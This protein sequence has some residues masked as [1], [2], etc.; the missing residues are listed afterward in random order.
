MA[1]DFFADNKP[2]DQT[3]TTENALSQSVRIGEKEYSYEDASR[4]VGLGEQA[5][6]L[7]TRWDTKIDK[8]MPAYSKSREEL[9]TLKEQA[10]ERAN[11][12]IQSKEA[13]GED[14]SEAEKAKLV[15]DEAKKLGL[16]TVDDL[17]SYYQNRRGGEQLLERIDSVVGNAEKQEYPAT[18]REDL[19][20]YMAET[21]IKDAQIAY[22]VMFRKDIREIEMK[23]LQSLRPQG[24]Y[25]TQS[26]TAGGKLPATVTPTKENLGQLLEEVLT[27]GGQ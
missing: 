16:V 13:K 4:L 12:Q 8:L 3:T 26:S 23:K 19:L 15:K 27:R 6:D 7:E 5:L 2:A 20:A 24:L 25:T 10:E 18:T 21:G 17:D 14:L 1:D 11:A 9:Q 22:E